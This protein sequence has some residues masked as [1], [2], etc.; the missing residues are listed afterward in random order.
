MKPFCAHIPSSLLI[1]VSGHSIQNRNVCNWFLHYS[2]RW[3]VGFIL[4]RTRKNAIN[5]RR[6]IICLSLWLRQVNDL[7][8]TDKSRYF[9]H[10]RSVYCEMFAALTLFHF[11]KKSV[12]HSLQFNIFFDDFL[13]LNKLVFLS[14]LSA[15]C[16]PWRVIARWFCWLQW[17]ETIV[18]GIR[19]N[20]FNSFGEMPNIAAWKQVA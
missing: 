1:F 4:L 17:F 18:L 6:S 2:R 14:K 16:S 3:T 12:K 13:L 20:S 11:C 8:A 5:Y 7:L 9:V 19:W 15:A 10:T